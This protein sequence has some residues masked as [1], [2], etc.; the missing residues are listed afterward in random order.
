MYH[1]FE[2]N[3]KAHN[4]RSKLE[5]YVDACQIDVFISICQMDYVGTDTADT[6]FY[7]QVIC[8]LVSAQDSIFG[9][10]LWYVAKIIY[11]S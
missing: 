5:R 8:R 7:I 6:T 9:L 4:A 3:K 2:E 11:L 10:I 1:E